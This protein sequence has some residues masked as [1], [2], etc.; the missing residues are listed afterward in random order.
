MKSFS[1]YWITSVCAAE[2]SASRSRAARA[3]WRRRARPRRASFAAELGEHRGNGLRLGDAPA[4]RE[5]VAG[6]DDPRR[7]ERVL[8]V[9]HPGGV[10]EHL[11]IELA[12]V[13]AAA[14]GLQAIGEI[15][16]VLGAFREILDDMALVAHVVLAPRAFPDVGP[17]RRRSGRSASASTRSSEEHRAGRRAGR[18]QDQP[19][20]PSPGVPAASRRRVLGSF[21]LK[22][23]RSRGR[24]N[25]PV[26]PRPDNRL[27]AARAGRAPGRLCRGRALVRDARAPEHRRGDVPVGRAARGRGPPPVRDFPFAQAPL[28][29]LHSRRRSSG[30]ARRSR[31]PAIALAVGVLGMAGALWLARRLAAGF[32]AL[33]ALLLSLATLPCSGSARPRA[34]RRSRRRCSCSASPHWRCAR[35]R[36]GWSLSPALL[37]A[38]AG[39]RFTNLGVRGGVRWVG[40]AL[41]RVPAR[42]AG[43]RIAAAALLL[44]R[45]AGA[46]ARPRKPR[47]GHHRAAQAGRALRLR[48]QAF[49]GDSR[50]GSAA[51][52]SCSPTPRAPDCSRSPLLAL[53]ALRGGALAPGR[54]AAGAIS[55]RRSCWP[56]S[57]RWR[58]RRTSHSATHSSST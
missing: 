49:A 27:L 51:I 8:P 18:R 12:V 46:A 2:R 11:V 52:S 33:I 47:S 23:P 55:A 10:H 13:K 25:L 48:R 5:R 20:W 57:A 14:A 35:W 19:G 43:G 34:H 29:R 24:E 6:D 21:P 4:H 7:R 30:L 31:R 38:A 16:V 50:A 22:S 1:Q 45:T 54:P 40:V 42:L 15:G 32:A 44:V 3:R 53:L 39:L 56:G 28:S 58:S 37:L 9:A 26:S 17:E 36:L 41:R